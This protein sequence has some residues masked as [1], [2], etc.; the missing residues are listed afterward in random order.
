MTTANAGKSDRPPR[1]ANNRLPALRGT[2]DFTS[3]LA[4]RG[5]ETTST[6]VMQSTI[7]EMAGIPGDRG[8]NVP[9]AKTPTLASINT[10]G[11]T[12]QQRSSRSDI[13]RRPRHSVF[14]VGIDLCRISVIQ[15]CP[16]LQIS[17]A[18][19]Y[20]TQRAAQCQFIRLTA[21]FSKRK[22]HE[23]LPR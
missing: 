22:T 4:N 13:Q 11:M 21:K 12:T 7:H 9:D 23:R 17:V 14:Q 15:Q 10:A 2:R 3:D 1:A 6:T 8:D 16:K 19:S 18:Q 20:D 5:S